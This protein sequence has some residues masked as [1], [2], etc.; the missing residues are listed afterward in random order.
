MRVTTKAVISA[1]AKAPINSLRDFSRQEYFPNHKY[2]IC[3]AHPD[4]EILS[5]SL[6]SRLVKQSH[7]EFLV[8]TNGSGNTNKDRLAELKK[9][10]EL[11]GY[12]GGV[13]CLIDENEIYSLA[14]SE[15]GV[16]SDENLDKLARVVR[17]GISDIEKKIIRSGAER[18]I[19]NAFEGGHFVH[20]LSNYM[21][22][23]AAKRTSRE[24]YENFQYS[25][26]PNNGVS[27]EKLFEV[28]N[29]PLFSVKPYAKYF[30]GIP[31]TTSDGLKDS[32]LGVK[33][34]W[35]DVTLSEL[36]LKNSLRKVHNSQ[37]KSLNRSSRNVTH[38]DFS[39]E[40]FERVPEHRDFTRLPSGAIPLY[41]FCNWR[42]SKLSFET[43]KELIKRVD[44]TE[45]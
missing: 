15:K 29:N 39:K 40:Y 20:D 30:G 23:L 41:P 12:M 4:D 45:R 27:K 14:K 31:L 32:S 36:L 35:L 42:E 24:V 5:A 38:V 3:F 28:I 9:S 17:R 25:L 19:T 18:I 1:F 33:G 44:S 16:A 6:C 34:G 10:Y 26:V 7:P 13:D 11:L 2:L 21:V 22:H 8:V 37:C 43:F